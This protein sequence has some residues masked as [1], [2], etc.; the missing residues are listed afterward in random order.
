M[1]L[2]AVKDELNGD[3]LIQNQSSGTIV[4]V[5]FDYSAKTHKG[6]FPQLVDLK[7][8]DFCDFGCKFCYQSSTK[9]GVHAKYWDSK[10]GISD[11]IDILAENNVISVALGGGE[12]TKHPDL[13][14]ILEKLKSKNIVVGM[15]TKNFDLADHPRIEEIKKLTNSIA[16]SCNSIADIGKAAELQTKLG[17]SIEIYVQII[18]ELHSID[19]LT[20]MLEHCKEKRLFRVTLLGYKDFGFGSNIKVNDMS[21][22]WINVIKKSGVHIGVDSCLAQKWGNQLKQAGVDEKYL[23]AEEGKF[24]CYID[25]VK[26]IMAPSSFTSENI[27]P[28]STDDELEKM[29]MNVWRSF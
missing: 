9:E 10:C 23:V 8:T 15:T 13:I 29:F 24:S 6:G 21:P 22:E 26:R 12:P 18:L 14:Q 16:V 1:S 7:I 28:F 11:I 2:I 25:A 5:N 19:V 17:Y 3:W 27:V 4:R 20:R